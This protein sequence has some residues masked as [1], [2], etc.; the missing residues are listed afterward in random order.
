MSNQSPRQGTC[1]PKE[2]QSHPSKCPVF[3]HCTLS[4]FYLHSA[5]Y[6]FS[7]IKDDIYHIGICN[8]KQL[9][10]MPKQ[11]GNLKVVHVAAFS[12]VA[13]WGGKKKKKKKK[14]PTLKH[15]RALSITCF[16][17]RVVLAAA[18]F[19][20]GTARHSAPFVRAGTEVAELWITRTDR[21][22]QKDALVLSN[23]KWHLGIH[24]PKPTPAASS[25]CSSSLTLRKKSLLAFPSALICMFKL[26]QSLI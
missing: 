21:T 16:I 23:R 7:K 4:P 2:I 19:L 8:W 17:F 24:Q 26:G 18:Y 22:H 12:N 9:K 14:Q 11:A 13:L 3:F 10:H 5:T 15:V 20:T 25:S 6:S 1:N